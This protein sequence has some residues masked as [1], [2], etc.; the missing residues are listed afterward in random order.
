MQMPVTFSA[1]FFFFFS[2]KMSISGSIRAWLLLLLLLLLFVVYRLYETLPNSC[3]MWIINVISEV[4]LFSRRLQN[5]WIMW[6]V[7]VI[8]EVKLFPQCMHF[9][10]AN[11]DKLQRGIGMGVF[12]GQTSIDFLNE[13]LVI[14]ILLSQDHDS[15][16]WNYEDDFDDKKILFHHRCHLDQH[17]HHNHCKQM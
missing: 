16:E 4:K 2:G 13:F 6:M 12:G 8:S 14:S 1:F 3:N 9:P 15:Y 5:S 7:S 11:T 17:R 10:P